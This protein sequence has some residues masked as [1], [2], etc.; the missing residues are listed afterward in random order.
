MSEV[1]QHRSVLRAGSAVAAGLALIVYI[2]SLPNGFL[3][4]DGQ[5]IAFSAVAGP[6]SSWRAFLVTPAAALTT[7]PP[8]GT[9]PRICPQSASIAL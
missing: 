3:S 7:T 8:A 2:N 4:D 6:P 1:R 9:F 5:V